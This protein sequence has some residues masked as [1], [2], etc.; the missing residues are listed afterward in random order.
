VLAG[1]RAVLI[2]GPAGAGK[3]QLALALLQ[4]AD[5]GLLRFARLVGDD[6]VHLEA[7]HG[8]LLVR[9]AAALAGLIEVRGLGVRQLEYEPVA[10]VGLLVDLAAE[11][12]ERIPTASEAV[13]LDVPV[14]RLALP[15][16]GAPLAPVL[17]LLRS[18]DGDIKPPS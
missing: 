4:A 12:A 15:P 6:R 16:G 2:R 9:P 5:T 13:L 8:R 3:S 14:R 1:S 10:V 11:D 7:R 17:A 18:P